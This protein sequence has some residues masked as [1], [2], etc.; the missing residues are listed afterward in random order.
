LKEENNSNNNG[1]NNNHHR[2]VV[3]IPAYNE[4]KEIGSIVKKAKTYA[5]E[6]IVCDDGS[7]DSTADVAKSSGATVIRHEKNEGYGASIKSLFEI[8]KEKDVDIMVTLDS[9]GQHNP[10]QIPIV[11]N[12]ILRDGYDIVIG[13]RFLDRRDKLKV[14]LYR[15][16]G[17]ATI[18]KLTQVASYG[19]ITDAQSGFRAYSKR[20]LSNMDLYED[21]MSV[22]TEIL[23]RAKE[24]HL[25]VQEV[26]VTVRYDVEDA[27][28][29]NPVVHGIKVM[30]NVLQYISLRHPLVFYGLPGLVMLVV[31]AIYAGNAIELFSHT[32][33]V[34]TPLILVAVGT[35]MIGVVLFATAAILYT[36]TALL[37]GRVRKDS[38]A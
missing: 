13:S 5:N 2:I 32:R 21:G 33:Y 35:A 36:I 25:T 31:G 24:N 37:K 6:V 17:I 20:A 8:A 7:K 10:E 28:T 12:P 29:H 16:L 11:L 3:C 14:P 38:V 34:S 23:L 4:A 22:S 30:S 19:N 9:D 18:T 15:S 1:N 27:S 26:P